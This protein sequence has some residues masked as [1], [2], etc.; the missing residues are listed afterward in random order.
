MKN[1]KISNILILML[2]I[3]FVANWTKMINISKGRI[4]EVGNRRN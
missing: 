2:W 4:K 3:N 1:L